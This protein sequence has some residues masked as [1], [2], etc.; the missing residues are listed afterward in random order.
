MSQS[1][2]QLKSTQGFMRWTCLALGL[3]MGLDPAMSAPGDGS[4]EMANRTHT[5]FLFFDYGLATYKSKLMDSNDTA[6]ALTYGF[7]LNAGAERSFGVEYRVESTAVSFETNQSSLTTSWTSTIFKYR[8]WAFELGPVL[9]SVKMAAKRESA[10]IFDIVGSGFG[11][12]FGILMPIGNSNLAYLNMM[13]VATATPVD[14][15]ARTV[16]M[17]SRMDLELGTKIKI[18][19][20]VVDFTVGYRRRTV[21]ITEDGT[22]YTELQTATFIGFNFGKTF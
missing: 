19:R 20:R 5:A 2:N 15:Q 9:G 4:D 11:G 22:P 10:E 13:S 14:T 12:Y 1:G 6:G 16:T 3:I 7:G 18:T 8:L 21:S 17:G